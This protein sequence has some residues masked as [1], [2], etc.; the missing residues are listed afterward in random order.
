[1]GQP[2]NRSVLEKNRKRKCK[3]EKIKYSIALIIL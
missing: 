3:L 2:I 1:M